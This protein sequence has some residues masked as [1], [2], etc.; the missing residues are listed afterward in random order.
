MNHPNE[1]NRA[2]AVYLFSR[3]IKCLKYVLTPLE[4]SLPV[5]ASMSFV[6][7]SVLSIF[8]LGNLL[9]FLLLYAY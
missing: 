1:R 3:F 4:I 2:R 7:V 8:V 6:S 5:D 9:N